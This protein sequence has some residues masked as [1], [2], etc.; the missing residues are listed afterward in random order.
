M[1]G[2]HKVVDFKNAVDRVILIKIGN[3][4]IV[5]SI[6]DGFEQVYGL[7]LVATLLALFI[8]LFVSISWLG[9]R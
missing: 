7:S 9:H 1:P 6:L 4:P 8:Y 5:Q 2:D 3:I